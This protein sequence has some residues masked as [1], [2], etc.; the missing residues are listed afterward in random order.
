VELAGRDA[1]KV[2]RDV[3]DSGARFVV[4]DRGDDAALRAALGE[5]ADLLVDCLCFSARDAERLVP[6]ARDAASTVMISSKAVYVDAAGRHANS[7]E[8]PHFDGPVAETQPTLAAAEADGDPFTREGYGPHKLAAERVLLESGLPVSILR[9]GKVHGDG[10]RPPREWV[11]VKRVL[12]RRTAVFLAHRGEG[13]DHPAAAANVAALIARV[14]E[15][16][17]ARI[18]NV[19]DP[20]APTALAI[21]RTIADAMGHTWDEVLLD[22]DALGRHPWESAAPVVLDLRAAHALGWLPAGSYAQ[23]VRAAIDALVHAAPPPDDALFATMFD[24]AAEDRISRPP[25]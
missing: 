9:V 1:S 11:F 10:A 5:G 14:A 3:T 23:T 2:P 13:V 22:D 16:P 18:L 12:D 7:D 20:D 6:L 15:V 25:R 21:A 8:R 24:Y 4:A 19:A 17:G